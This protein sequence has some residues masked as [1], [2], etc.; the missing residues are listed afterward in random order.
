MVPQRSVFW[1]VPSLALAALPAYAQDADALAKQLSNPIS[2]LISVPLQFNYDDGIGPT[3]DGS[4]AFVNVQPVI[5]VSISEHWNMISRT[6]VPIVYQEDI[7]PGAGSQFGT[8]DTLQSL[9]FSPKA[10]TTSGWI[11][12]VGPVFYIP[13]ASDDLLGAEKWGAGPTAVVL[14]QT[15]AA[16]LTAR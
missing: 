3:N 9:F 8:G 16:G 1:T 5:P 12:G 15:Q 6:I 2:S 7:F 10:P 4:K 14:K 11:W 13:T